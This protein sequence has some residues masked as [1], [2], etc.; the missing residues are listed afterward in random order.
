MYSRETGLPFAV[1][2]YAASILSHPTSR[3][4]G[5][6]YSMTRDD[7]ARMVR[8]LLDAHGAGRAA[9]VFEGGDVF[10][11]MLGRAELF[12]EYDEDGGVLNCAALVYRFRREPRAGVLQ[13]FFA[14]EAGG[15]ADASGGSLEYRHD[16]RAL[17]LNRFYREPVPASEFAA[18]VKRLAEASLIWADE[19]LE[20]VASSATREN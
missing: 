14:E 11:V 4:I 9:E 6:D 15:A 5:R 10:G 7:A 20:R 18:D 19:I 2:A 17:L 13:R 8:T 3:H 1:Y 12:F 16:T